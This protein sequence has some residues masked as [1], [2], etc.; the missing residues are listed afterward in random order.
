MTEYR[1]WVR[2]SVNALASATE[3]ADPDALADA[4]IVL[5]DGALAT[6]K[7]ARTARPAAI[8]ANRIARLTVAAAKASSPA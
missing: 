4:L 2:Q 5:Y 8:T 3:V 7:L 6:A 1:H